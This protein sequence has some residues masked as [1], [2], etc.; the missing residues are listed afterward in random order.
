M[1][2]LILFVGVL[3]VASAALFAKMGL[4]AGVSAIGL[5]AWRLTVAAGGLAVWSVAAPKPSGVD[6]RLAAKLIVAGLFLALHFATWIASLE[7]VSIA[8]STLLVSTAP[9]WAGLF[10]FRVASLRA[11]RLFWVGLPV[12][13]IGTILVVSSGPSV[14]KGP[15]WLGDLL[16]MAGA[17]CLVPYLAISQGAQESIGTRRTVTWIYSVA[18]ISLWVFLFLTRAATIPV[19]AE[20]W[21]SIVGMAVFAQLIGHSS[22]N[23]SLKHF[24]TPQVA[25]STLLEPVF[26]GILAWVIL[27]ERITSLQMLG[28]VILLFGLA[29]I[30]RSD[31]IAAGEL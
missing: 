19:A 30:L 8:R 25:S 7:Y 1:R 9:L 23:W 12:A 4:D 22:L 13:A 5:S 6:R 18:A 11:G 24:S 26:A 14:G 20:A 10:G 28:G 27:G 2:Y 16:A 31:P 29:I 17:I 21:I 3:G 15:A